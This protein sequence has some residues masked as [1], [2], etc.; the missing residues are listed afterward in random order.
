LE[1]ALKEFEGS[2]IVVSHDRWFLNRVVDLLIVL[3]GDGGSEVI[4][5]NYD[6]YE[7][8]RATKERSAVS[9]QP[10]AEKQERPAASSTP[11]KAKRKRQFPYRKI[12]E[13]EAEIADEERKLKDL[14][15]LM[16]SPDLYRD[17]DKVKQTTQ[18]FE[19]TKAR[20]AYLYEHWEEAV[21]LNKK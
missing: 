19:D 15:A 3:D 4:Y 11:A 12:E 7:L 17:G 9:D 1:N 10:S 18:A 16:A 8:M 21:E 5:G 6:T 20:I 13:I 2:A 14:E